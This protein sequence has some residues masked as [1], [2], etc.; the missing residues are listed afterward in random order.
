MSVFFSRFLSLCI[1][2]FFSYNASGQEQFVLEINAENGKEDLIRQFKAPATMQ[3]SSRL[4]LELRN[5][6]KFLHE[7]GYLLATVKKVSFDGNKAVANLSIGER[8]EWL[9]LEPGNIEKSLLR[10]IGYSEKDFL[11]KPFRIKAFTRLEEKLLSYAEENGYPFASLKVDS[12]MI[13]D[14]QLEA[15]LQFDTGPPIRFDSLQIRGTTRA[16]QKFL[17]KYLGITQGAL[18]DQKR[19]RDI[20]RALNNLSYLR[21]LEPPRLTFQNSEATIFLNLEERKINQL[22]GI[23]GFLPNSSNTGRFLV[24]GQFD[25]ELFNPFGSGRHIGIHWQKLNTNSQS[26]A[27]DYE[28]PNIFKGPL[29]LDLD[30]DFLKEDTLFTN[31]TLRVDLNYRLSGTASF[32][33]YSDFKTTNLLATS[34]YE[35]ITELPDL[36]DF[37]FNSYGLR[38]NWQ[39]FDDAFLPKDGLRLSIEGSAGNKKIVQNNGIAAELYQGV[40]LKT[41]QYT[42]NFLGEKYTKL[43]NQLTLLNRLQLGEVFNDRLFRNDAYRL[44]GFNSIRGFNENFFFA[45]SYAFLTTEFR[46]FLD[47][48]SYLSLFGDL[49]RLKSEFEGT[50]QTFSPVGLGAGISFSTNAGIFNFVYALGS[51]GDGTGINLSLSKVHFG[52][53]SRF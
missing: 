24:T 6:L 17:E 47:E 9:T 37:D 10:K 38:F 49:A 48:F 51:G 30:F 11:G 34:I 18:F 50:D 36:V 4:R 52:Y 19:V 15:I 31:R 40:R 22:D 21:L 44:G 53:V 20:G 8:F 1:L 35:G 45:T 3:D 46:F 42:F 23:I 43:G 5:Y 39:K 41:F 33:A 29:D 28:Q 14:N 26:L 2:I 12:L 25:V 32:S 27:L 13:V 7:E 16:K